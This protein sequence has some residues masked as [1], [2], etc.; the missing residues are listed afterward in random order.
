V[1]IL[2]DIVDRK[3]WERVKLSG[4]YVHSLEIEKVM[5]C[6]YRLGRYNSTWWRETAM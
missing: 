1:G 4:K 5:R 2:P 6:L 3:T